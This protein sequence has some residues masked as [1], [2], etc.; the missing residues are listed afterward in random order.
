MK[1][2]ITTVDEKRGIV[3]CTSLDERW[4]AVPSKDPVTNLPTY[5]YY[6]SS[7]WVAGYDYMP[8]QLLEWAKKNGVES[9][10]IMVDAAARGSKIHHAIE[11]IIAGE[12]LE[13]DTKVFNGQSGQEE[14]LTVDEWEVVK[15]FVDW[16]NEVKPRYI[17][18][19]R[20]VIS[21]KYKY[22]GTLDAVAKIGDTLYLIDFK[23]SKAIYTSHRVQIASYKHALMEEDK[24]FENISLAVLQVGYRLNRKGWKFTEIEDAFPRFLRD[25]ATWKDEN[26]EAKPRQISLPISFQIENSMKQVEPV[27]QTTQT[28]DKS[29]EPSVKVASAKA[30]KGNKSV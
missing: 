5:D 18:S 23:T 11:K 17:L 15:T 28:Y 19:E 29:K 3:Q 8:P 6:P 7:S 10:Q 13:M 14:E 4:Y 30:S 16:N 22:G 9:D 2:T 25:Y 27:T 1:K 12:K 21:N 24:R 26:P 20:T